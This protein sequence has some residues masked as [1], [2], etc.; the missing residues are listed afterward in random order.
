MFE[1]VMRW[2]LWNI[3]AWKPT[4]GD[5]GETESWKRC[6]KCNQ[7]ISGNGFILPGVHELSVSPVYVIKSLETDVN[8]GCEQGQCFGVHHRQ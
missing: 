8:T 3:S 1:R 6:M 4:A 7:V 2:A 5:W